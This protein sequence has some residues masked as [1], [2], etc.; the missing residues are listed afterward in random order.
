LIADRELSDQIL[1]N[2]AEGN[3][4]KLLSLEGF[5]IDRMIRSVG[6]RS[7]IMNTIH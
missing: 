1:N 2:L 7:R 5:L 4:L 3:M 6:E